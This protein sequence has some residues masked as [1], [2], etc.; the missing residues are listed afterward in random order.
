MPQVQARDRGMTMDVDEPTCGT[1]PFWTA[2]QNADTDLIYLGDCQRYPPTLVSYRAEDPRDGDEPYS[3]FPYTDHSQWCGEHPERQHPVIEA[4]KSDSKVKGTLV[5]VDPEKGFT[6]AD[7]L[8]VSKALGVEPGPN[9][10]ES[11]SSGNE[12]GT[13]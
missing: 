7:Y 1:C 10:I 6:Y 5:K 9:D 12:E 11:P 8:D 13:K 4:E 3:L 2:Y